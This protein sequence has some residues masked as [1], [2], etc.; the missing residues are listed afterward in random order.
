MQS[1]A[2]VTTLESNLTSGLSEE[3]TQSLKDFAKKSGWPQNITSKLEVEY[4][5]GALVISYPDNLES[6]ISELEYGT[7]GTPP[8]A[9]FR[10]FEVRM[11]DSITRASSEIALEL[12]MEGEL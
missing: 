2:L 5:D 4:Q 6:K 12:F 8:R 10:P 11:R 9:V 1:S 7:T 3:L